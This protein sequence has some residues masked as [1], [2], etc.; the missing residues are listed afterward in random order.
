[1]DTVQKLIRLPVVLAEQADRRADALGLSLNDLIVTT[2]ASFL[3]VEHDG[4][5]PLLQKLSEWVS[6]KFDR[7]NFPQDVT[8]QVFQHILATPELLATYMA[9]VQDDKGQRDEQKKLR[10]NQRIGKMVKRCLEAEVGGRLGPFDPAK[11]L[12][13]SCALLRPRPRHDGGLTH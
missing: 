3:G 12:I 9:L 2:L 5:L 1:M 10:L 11:D 4:D 7:H 6:A 13:Q 8:W